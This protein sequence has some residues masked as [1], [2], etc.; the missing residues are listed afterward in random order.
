MLRR[1]HPAN[2]ILRKTILF[3]NYI[4]DLVDMFPMSIDTQ[5]SITCFLNCIRNRLLIRR[6]GRN[7]DSF[8]NFTSPYLTLKNWN[9]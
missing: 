9:H 8:A 4:N 7:N 5:K 1:N 3:L 6:V 2:I